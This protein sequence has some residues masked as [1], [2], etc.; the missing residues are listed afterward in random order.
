MHDNPILG[1]VRERGR[2]SCPDH[3]GGVGSSIDS[4]SAERGRVTY[5]SV[6]IRP[7]AIPTTEPRYTILSP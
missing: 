3:Q 5:D 6:P 2:L 7:V 1:A 4:T